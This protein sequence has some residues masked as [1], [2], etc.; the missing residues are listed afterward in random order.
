MD[1]AQGIQLA[2][3][4][5][6][7]HLRENLQYKNI[8]RQACMSSFHFQ[9][10]FAVLCGCTVG[11]YIRN[12]RLTLAAEELP[13]TDKNITD[14]ALAWG[15]DTPEGF[16]RAFS[17]YFGVT[18]SAAR[19]RGSALPPFEKI[20][21]RTKLNGDADKMDKLGKRGYAVLENG[22]VYYTL[23][24]DSTAQWFENVLGWY[25]GIDARNDEG[26]GTYGCVLP[27]PG[28]LVH[29][30][31]ASFNGIHMFYGEPIRRKA[32]FILIDGIE[33]LHAF[34]RQNGWEQITDIETQ[35]WGARS[36]DVTTVDGAILTFFELL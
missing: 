7:E 11:E 16:A 23:D 20:I 12:R 33:K 31:I 15:Y 24:M 17:R 29:M 34:V 3:D 8:A 19:S 6:E 10:V 22:P 25:A 2:I 30:Q 5:M 36:C 4:Y 32:G 13:A 14:I 35:P 18:P 27:I 28:E 21:V 1:T 26:K 9:R